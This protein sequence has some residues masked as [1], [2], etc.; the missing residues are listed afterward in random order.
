[1]KFIHRFAGVV[2]A[3][4][5]LFTAGLVLA[6][7]RTSP[8]VP[9]ANVVRVELEIVRSGTILA[10]PAFTAIS[11]SPVRLVLSGGEAGEGG[12]R[13]EAVAEPAAP[14]S[15]GR[16]TTRLRF[17][18]FEEVAGAWVL[19]GQPEMRVEDGNAATVEVSGG[20][21]S[22]SLNV[23][24]RSRFDATADRM[25]VKPCPDAEIIASGPVERLDG[26]C[27][28]CDS[29]P[30]PMCKDCCQADCTDGSGRTLRC[31]G[32]IECCDGV[33]GACCSP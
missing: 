18:L 21:G 23:V 27:P 3:A 26:A 9:E 4:V 20:L 11:G 12:L 25:A 17:Q 24:A 15:R 5:L 28:Q 10:T 30:C 1:M 14:S 19:A 7:P 16:P 6:Q 2:P 8:R 32:A 22:W 29:L 33:C 31:C 13:I